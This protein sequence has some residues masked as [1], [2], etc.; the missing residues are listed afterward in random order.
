MV[1]WK[2]NIIALLHNVIVLLSLRRINQFGFWGIKVFLSILS[3]KILKVLRFLCLLVSCGKID[4]HIKSKFF[5]WLV[6]HKKILTKD[7]L[8]KKNWRGN[9][10]CIFCGFSESIDHLFFQCSVARFT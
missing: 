4:S 3:T 8:F 1:L 9:L 7:N 5:L 2:M 6:R 10:D